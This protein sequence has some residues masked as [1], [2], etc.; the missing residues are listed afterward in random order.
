MRTRRGIEREMAVIEQDGLGT[1]ARQLLREAKRMWEVRTPELLDQKNIEYTKA[2]GYPPREV[3]DAYEHDKEGLTA[4]FGEQGAVRQDHLFFHGTGAMKY[5]GDKYDK[6][7]DHTAEV[8]P[9]LE[10]VLR[11]G[12]IPHNDR[13]LPT[14]D[15]RSTSL[16]GSYFYTKWF[17]DKYNAPE[18]VPQWQYGDPNDYFRF[19]MADTFRSELEPSRLPSAVVSYLTNKSSMGKLKKDRSK[20][21]PNRLYNWNTSF[22]SDVD[23][24]TSIEQLLEGRSD[25]AGNFG[26]VLCFDREG[27]D[28]MQMPV[29]G[30]HEARTA[31]PIT[32]DKIRAI[33]VP[34][35]EVDV[36]RQMV[37]DVGLSAQVFSTEST[38]MH[39]MPHSIEELVA[40][41]A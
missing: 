41:I 23:K 7:D 18:N 38:D 32:S 31:Q 20:T 13:W 2:R 33:I 9:V 11:D 24:D 25:I 6:S 15:T 30:A 14:E 34:L 19:F 8:E 40:R 3:Q 4:L 28:Q 22:R 35:S 21:N 29:G 5:G 1:P 10:G 26:A 36:V 16:A 12:I 27:I 17:A 39:L 37:Q